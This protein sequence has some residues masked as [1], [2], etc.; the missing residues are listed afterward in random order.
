MID[1]AGIR[2]ELNAIG[3]NIN[4]ITHAFHVVE[5]DSQKVFHALRVA[6][7]YKMVRNQ[8]VSEEFIERPILESG[9]YIGRKLTEYIQ[10]KSAEDTRYAI[11]GL[12]KNKIPTSHL[13]PG[14]YF[15]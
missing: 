8:S 14:G 5:A 3:T 11:S 13:N 4:Q 12:G 10:E 7:Q 6:E 1:L 15:I 2:K 9:Y